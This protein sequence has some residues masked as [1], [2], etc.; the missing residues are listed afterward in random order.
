MFW[1]TLDIW[2]VHTW[3][4]QETKLHYHPGCIAL[5]SH[6]FTI[7]IGSVNIWD[8]VN[9]FCWRGR[10]SKP[11]DHQQSH[12]YE[13]SFQEPHQ[14]LSILLLFLYIGKL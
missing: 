6:N 7:T 11:I 12:A 10:N 4:I 8:I 1:Y 14:Q 5:L 13:S 9:Q 3:A 2:H